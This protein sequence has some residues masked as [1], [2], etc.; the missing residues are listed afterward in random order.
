MAQ[1]TCLYGS[2]AAGSLN[3]WV[4]GEALPPPPNFFVMVRSIITKKLQINQSATLLIKV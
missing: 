3:F 4:Q 2:M 1:F